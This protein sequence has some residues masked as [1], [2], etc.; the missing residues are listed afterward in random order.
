MPHSQRLS[1]NPYPEPKISC[2]EIY[3]FKIHSNVVFPST[4]KTFL[5]C[6][7]PID[8]PIN[9]LKALLPSFNLATFQAHLNLPDL[10]TLTILCK[11]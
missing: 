8:F 4:L 7:I 5:E 1:N 9:I 6:R 3:F 11:L 10:I 2:I